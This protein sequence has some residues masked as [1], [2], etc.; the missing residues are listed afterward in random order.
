MDY[1]KIRDGF[2][3]VRRK[4]WDELAEL[5]KVEVKTDGQKADECIK[6]RLFLDWERAEYRIKTPC[7]PWLADGLTNI[8][9]RIIYAARTQ[10]AI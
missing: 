8:Q 2:I 10:T 1:T 6:S 7:R 5:S 9:R 3:P 4:L